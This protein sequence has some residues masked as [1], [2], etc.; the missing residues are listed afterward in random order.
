[1]GFFFRRSAHIGPFRLNFSK[2]GIGASVGVKGARLTM[3]PR[4]TT[5]ITV[6]GHGFYYRETL[7]NG[8][9]VPA[10][11]PAIPIPP[12][13]TRSSD[14]I[15]TADV[16]DLVDSS[17]ETLIQR[18]N[19][20]A[21]MF[22]PAWILYAT[23]LAICL[24]ALV[25]FSGT[26]D[27][28]LPDV[29]SPLSTERKSN[30]VDEYSTF[31]NYFGYPN[32]VLAT[33]QA[34]IVPVRTAHYSYAHVKVVFVPNGCV[35]AYD[36]AVRTLAERSRYPALAKQGK[37]ST[38]CVTPANGGWTI[39]G[40]LDPAD[41]RALSIETARPRLNSITV[42]QTTP[43]IVEVES[44]PVS[45]QKPNP[46]TLPKNKLQ[47][48]PD[49]PSDKQTWALRDPGEKQNG[50]SADAWAR[51]SQSALL[52]S[53]LGL[54]V[55]GIVVHRNNTENRTS[56]LFYELDETEQ[57]KYGIVQE[58]LA[59]LGK[60]NRTWRIEAKSA[61]SDW[62]RNAGAS[63]LVRRV[64]IN[65]SP[66]NPPRVEMNLTVPCINVGSVKVFFLPDVVLYLERGTYG[67]IAY[68][69]LRVEHR[70]SR[71]IED[72]NVPADATVVDRTWRYVNK[73]GGPDR[74][75]NNNV[76]LPVVQYGALILMSSRGLNIHLNTSNAQESLAF[77]NCWRTLRDHIGKVEG[78]QSTSSRRPDVLG[79]DEGALKMLGLNANASTGEIS[80]AYRHLAQMYHPDKVAG[81]APE[82]QMLA[83]KRMK[84]INA[85]YEA[86]K[87]RPQTA[88]PV[89][90]NA[91]PTQATIQKIF[92]GESE[93]AR[94]LAQEHGPSWEYLLTEELLRSKL[95]TVQKQFDSFDE[96][97]S[98]ATKRSFTGTEYVDWLHKKFEDYNSTVRQLGQ[99]VE[100]DLP[101]AWG[102]PGESGDAIKIFEAV[103][104]IAEHCQ[105]LFRWE[106]EV[107]AAD[108]PNNLRRLGTALRGIGARILSEVCRLPD[109]LDNAVRSVGMGRHQVR[110][111]L[112]F[113]GSPQMAACLKE[114][115]NIK[116]HPD[117]LT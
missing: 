115:E 83:D 105:V 13:A 51:Y 2:S 78:Q 91:P 30:T 117:W 90:Q 98:H 92:A 24:Y 55:V 102:K 29:T 4:G 56:R 59:H 20:R 18:L 48:K 57:R 6:G 53:G 16:A 104:T 35:G 47:P 50:Q 116:A 10:S 86:L 111:N 62:K 22:N 7:S 31:V 97:V 12:S 45:K 1:M 27:I 101:T 113:A 33:E 43:P 84:E 58:A 36:E 32:S 67:G 71:F 95:A 107:S 72:E 73:S 25:M 64:P 112:N 63:S 80:A 66:S 87:Q 52:L 49:A 38:R 19:E 96:A 76:Q 34:S 94:T 109:E 54:F 40:Y 21:R 5:Y 60:S 69:D 26:S 103:A 28:Y 39:V 85:A 11:A 81:L 79:S 15:V 41:N 17:S 8:K 70:V 46:R 114:I 110:I 82:F 42:K 100:M 68:D 14:E 44:V 75:F 9:R 74:R 65:V 106:L 61:T 108:P 37:S 99:S 3:T 77:A 88:G 23:G 89:Q 93:K